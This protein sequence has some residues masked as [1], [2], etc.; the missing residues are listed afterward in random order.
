MSTQLLKDVYPELVSEWH[1]TKNGTLFPSQITIGSGKKVWWQ[2]SKGHEWQAIVGSRIKGYNCPYC[3]GR[4]VLKGVNDLQ[5]KYP[6]IANDWDY[7]KNAP[8]KPLDIM[9][10]NGKMFWWRCSKGH[11]WQSTSNNRVQGRGCP[12]CA[13]KKVIIG[14]NDLLSKNPEL[15]EEWDYEKNYPLRP[16]DVMAGR[17]KK[18]WWKCKRCG[19]EWEANISRR[20]RGSGCPKCAKRFH[21]SF[22]E[23]AIFFYIHKCYPDAINSYKELFDQGM[24][25]DIYIPSLVTGIEYDGERAHS[26]DRLMKDIRKYQICKRNGITLIRIREVEF[27]GEIPICDLQIH[28]KYTSGNYKE[29]NRVIKQLFTYIKANIDIDVERDEIPILEQIKG[30]LKS[31]SLDVEYPELV[32]EW[33]YEK[34]GTL[35][36][37]MFYAGN[38]DRVWWRCLKGHEWKAAIYPRTKGIGCPYCSNKKVLAGYNDLKTTDPDLALEWDQEKN[39]GLSPKDVTRKS[40]K[41]VFW[42]CPNGHSYEMKI[43]HRTNGHACPYCAGRK[44][45]SKKNDLATL[46]PELL[47]EWD[48]TLNQDI[49][50]Q[51]FLPGSEKKVWWKC[52]KCG[53]VWKTMI[54]NR[55]RGTGCPE[56]GKKLANSK[57]LESRIRT[58]GSLI[59]WC[60]AH[61]EKLIL[62]DEWNPSNQIKTNEVLP[63]SHQKIMWKCRV[64]GYQWETEVYKRTSYGKNCPACK[65]NVL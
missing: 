6:E 19:F 20:N 65:K 56:C 21:S 57:A 60:N 11:E 22:P 28:S 38:G 62:L 5:T 49:S 47:E 31:R 17:N 23:Q 63:N 15:A 8:I 33:N 12:Y 10:N 43:Y 46:F 37:A 26:K 44:A 18:A 27:H 64:C 50:P 1:P 59:E 16:E 40:G 55:V 35:I 25:L 58:K 9:P 13:G 41:K 54:A 30:V 2:C 24:E 48:Y 3:S 32:E 34:N 61:P 4:K 36:P 45:I 29:L 39:I 14:E 53:N 52:K 51:I 42:K 7:N